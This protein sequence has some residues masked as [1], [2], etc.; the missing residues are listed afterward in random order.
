MQARTGF[1]EHSR[2]TAP[3]RP[4]E[5][6][7]HDYREV[8]LPLP[9]HTAREQAS[10]CM[11]CGV[12]FCH[13][14]CPLG[15]LIPEWNDLV[16]RDDWEAA[17]QRLHLT[18]NFP[19]FTGRL[20]PAPC[21]PACVLDI[22]DDPVTIKS[23]EQA[24]IDRAFDE[25]WVRA[26]PPAHRTGKRVAVVGSGPAGLAAAQQ[27]N[28]AGHLV[29]VYEKADRVGGL[30]RYG[31]P[32]FK[33]EKWV[34]D[35]R[36]SL[37]EAE[38]IIFETG[39]E[40]GVDIGTDR[41]RATFDA[42]VL[43]VGAERARDLECAGRDLNGV[44]LAM[45]YLAQQN[46]RVAGDRV[47]AQPEIRAAGKRVVIIGGG[48]TGADCLGNVIREHCASVEQLYIY[49]QPPDARPDSTPWPQWPLILRTYPAHEE[50]GS[51]DFAVMVTGFSGDDG[52][53]QR[54]HTVRV[55]VE[56][57][58]GRRRFEPISG[59]E[60]ILDADIVM[61]AI[62]FQGPP[63]LRV[64]EEL[65]VARDATGNLRVGEDFATDVPG[66]FA[67][68]DASRGASLIVWAIADGRL[69]ARSCDRYL[70]GTTLLP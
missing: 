21:E 56:R 41:L 33:M 59:S 54:V 13:D 24:I 6:R 47:T 57:E 15:N 66:V 12:A 14:G 27:L 67:A 8:Y 28:H 62:G 37:L 52:S 11:D 22:N 65:G 23:I 40:V 17:I 1:L 64:I 69:A 63:S 20:C 29:T 2:R 5:E 16:R 38:G 55:N 60:A 9:V 19:E 34:L 25:G 3:R 45:D 51:R 50:G 68:G 26:E 53:V 46:R 39:Y 42:V 48:D 44:H 4:V 35:R 61:L 18:N 58:E 32:D 36:L 7:V 43:A 49:P 10:R 31:I 70:M 30:L